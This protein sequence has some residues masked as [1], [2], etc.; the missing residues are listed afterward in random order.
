MVLTHASLTLIDVASTDRA[1]RLP[2]VWA[3]SAHAASIH[4]AGVGS[5][6][7]AAISFQRLLSSPMPRWASHSRARSRV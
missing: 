1:D 6:R 5:L 4:A 7:R 2:F 3:L